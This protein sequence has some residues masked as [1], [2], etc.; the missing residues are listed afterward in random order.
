MVS[1]M[2]LR[3]LL[4]IRGQWVCVAL[5][6]F[7]TGNAADTVA[8]HD[9][10][11]IE[12]RWGERIPMRDGIHLNATVYLPEN[13]Q[14]PAPCIFTLTPY[15]SDTYHDRGEYFAARGYPFLSVDVRGRGNS[16]GIFRPYTEQAKDGYDVV[17]WLAHQPYCNGKVAMWGGS[18]AGYEQWATAKEM[19]PHLSTIVPVASPFMGIDWPGRN[20][21]P[22]TYLVRLLAYTQG[23]ALQSNLWLDRPFWESTY[24]RWVKS[25]APFCELDQFAGNP[26]S[27]FQEWMA[28]PNLDVYWDRLNPTE[29]QYRSISIPV[30][31]ITAM[32]DVD[33]PGALMHYREHLR[34]ASPE[35]RQ[36]HYLVIGPW[37]HAG[38]RTPQAEVHGL[39]L[40]PASLVDLPKLHLQWYAWTLQG[41]N[42][43]EF[44]KK[45]VAYYVTG[46]ET[47][48]YADS[49]D[50]V[51]AASRPYY[52]RST[53]LSADLP[54]KGALTA[55]PAQTNAADRYVYD[56]RDLAYVES[57]SVIDADRVDK[58]MRYTSVANQLIYDSDPFEQDTE[59]S[60]FFKLAAWLA[61]DQP[62]TDFAVSIYEMGPN[63]FSLF[64]SSDAMR[65]RYRES[66]REA[67]LI[68]TRAPLRYDF[69][70]FT[71][72]SRQIEKNHWLRLVI[73]PLD[74][75]YAQ[76][77]LNSGGPV[78]SESMRDA[79]RVTVTLY[80]D[81]VHPSALYVPV[82]QSLSPDE[83]TAPVS[84][85]ITTE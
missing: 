11:S 43:P 23:H 53:T 77:N 29:E 7:S 42:K 18:Y 49:L 56:P 8:A 79:R 84:A 39:K 15:V 54:K 20:N 50:A 82:G 36:R 45:R 52:L 19:P 32:Y 17:E 26:S 12:F 48:R 25:G 62:D 69:E 41:G 3:M 22:Y 14:F 72:A 75:M 55:S 40:G 59:V 28:H 73:S 60:G 34:N 76:R 37:D 4:A 70:R 27:V 80:H 61:I 83:P 66:A 74:S 16:E 51:T 5:L 35:E 81:A 2:T 57:E 1:G 63:R 33:Q 67:K 24:R 31:S 21:I 13:Q 47:W 6:I 85:F 65:A 38:T 71:F 9:A 64:L 68:R 30:L 46:S 58:R 78:A 10:A 44:L